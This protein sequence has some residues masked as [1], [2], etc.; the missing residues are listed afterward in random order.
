MVQLVESKCYEHAHVTKPKYSLGLY[1]A[2]HHQATSTPACAGLTM[3]HW[4]IM[5]AAHKHGTPINDVVYKLSN[6][7]VRYNFLDA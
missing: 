5:Q 1:C 7:T 2:H 4:L 3:S 6:N